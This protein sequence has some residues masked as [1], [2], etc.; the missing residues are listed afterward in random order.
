MEVQR[1]FTDIEL[2][3]VKGFDSAAPGNI[4]ITV[5]YTENGVSKSVDFQISVQIPADM[6]ALNLAI[7]MGTELEK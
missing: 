5:T 6:T 1:K 3:Q 7:A 2:M 4:L